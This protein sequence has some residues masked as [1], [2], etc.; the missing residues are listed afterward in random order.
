MQ[1]DNYLLT[2]GHYKNFN[3]RLKSCMKMMSNLIENF[4]ATYEKV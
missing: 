4:K 1:V 2:A 3:I